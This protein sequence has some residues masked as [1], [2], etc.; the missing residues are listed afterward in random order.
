V[1]TKPC[2]NPGYH[3]RGLGGIACQLT[4]G[5]APDV[6]GEHLGRLKAEAADQRLGAGSGPEGEVC[7]TMLAEFK[8]TDPRAKPTDH[9]LAEW[10][11]L[12]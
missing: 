4:A 11:N 5:R 6:F 9:G 12:W 10:T 8:L 1:G 7:G 3:D 2:G